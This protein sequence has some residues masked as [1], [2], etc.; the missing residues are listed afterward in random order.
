MYL[1][2]QA[3][4]AIAEIEYNAPVAA[5]HYTTCLS[6]IIPLNVDSQLYPP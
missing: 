2:G 1:L 5:I 4:E 3:P 6:G